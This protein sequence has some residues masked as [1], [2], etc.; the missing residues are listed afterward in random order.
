MSKHVMDLSEKQINALKDDIREGKYTFKEIASEYGVEYPSLMYW[1]QRHRIPY[2]LKTEN[3]KDMVS[4]MENN[5]QEENATE[6]K[7]V[8]DELRFKIVK[9]VISGDKM[10]V[11]ASRYGLETQDVVYELQNNCVQADL[12][13]I[14]TN[15][16]LSRK[17]SLRF[18]TI[19][20]IIA[21]PNKKRNEF[22]EDTKF[23]YNEIL[24]SIYFLIS[25]GVIQKSDYMPVK[26]SN[27]FKQMNDEEQLTF[28]E[29]VYDKM[30]NEDLA[31]M[32]KIESYEV[33]KILQSEE[34]T[35]KFEEF[36]ASKNTEVIQEKTPEKEEIQEV[37]KEEPIKNT[38]K[39]KSVLESKVH[40]KIE[41][42]DERIKNLEDEIRIKTL[43]LEKLKLTIRVQEIDDEIMR[44]TKRLSK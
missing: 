30:N 6:I 44:I 8:D 3:G 20:Y 9:D 27:K 11:I 24:Q 38:P 15:I 16:N 34:F 10:S 29:A 7:A 41:N 25:L 37:V 28:V 5:E 33:E 23:K 12:N 14:R 43:E 31:D 19:C 18:N 13:T 22:R 36:K 40:K 39:H 21:N 26:I 32:F 4:N 17:D 2:H 1:I 42:G 35:A